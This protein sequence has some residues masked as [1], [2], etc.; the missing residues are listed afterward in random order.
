MLCICIKLQI[1]PGTATSAG[2][3]HPF[4]LELL[5]PLDHPGHDDPSTPGVETSFEDNIVLHLDFTITDSNGTA[6]PGVVDVNIDDDSPV[7]THE[8][9]VKLTVE[10]NDIA[11]PWSLGTS[12]N[13][14]PEFPG[15]QS[16]TPGGGGL[17]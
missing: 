4:T 10:E 11:T 13:T 17:V 2:N 15:A 12:P 3:D 5:G 7:L 9:A 14:N 6:T 16:V 1:D 8:P